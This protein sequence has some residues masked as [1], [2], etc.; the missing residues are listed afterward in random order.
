MIKT[1]I[2]ENI[3]QYPKTYKIIYKINKM[4][5]LYDQKTIRLKIK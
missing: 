5:E 4:A 1:E 2:F 3:L